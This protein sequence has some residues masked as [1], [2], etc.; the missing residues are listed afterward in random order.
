MGVSC[1]AIHM[2]ILYGSFLW[3]N[4]SV[5]LYGN[6]QNYFV[7]WKVY[8]FE[9]FFYNNSNYMSWVIGLTFKYL[10]VSLTFHLFFVHCFSVKKP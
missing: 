1:G 2:W 9:E 5:N 6:I 3:R 4:S 8:K 7:S 10:F